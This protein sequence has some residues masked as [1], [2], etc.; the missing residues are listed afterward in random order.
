MSKRL[1]QKIGLLGLLSLLLCSI[2][3]SAQDAAPAALRFAE[4]EFNFGKIPQGKP[5]YHN[6]A[7]VNNSSQPLKIDNIQ[8]SCGCTTPEW[9][10]DAIAPGAT[11]QIKVGYNAAAEGAF[12]KTITVVAGNSTQV[13]HIK[14]EVWRTPVTSAPPNASVQFLKKKLGQ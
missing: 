12:D 2:S 8:A 13:L 5:V 1:L 6:F 11:A 7:V 3:V 14:G 10:R 4:T 9:S